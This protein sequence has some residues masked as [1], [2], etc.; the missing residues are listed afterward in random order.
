MFQVLV[1]TKHF[2]IAA[3]IKLVVSDDYNII[4][5]FFVHAD[6]LKTSKNPFVELRGAQNEYLH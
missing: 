3:N 1:C 4:N 2:P 6:I 5:L